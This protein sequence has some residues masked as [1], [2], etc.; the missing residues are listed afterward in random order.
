[1]QWKTRYR[2]P[3]GSDANPAW[4]SLISYPIGP[5]QDEQVLVASVPLSIH[6]S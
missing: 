1:M 4:A 3:G 6:P 2:L 5:W